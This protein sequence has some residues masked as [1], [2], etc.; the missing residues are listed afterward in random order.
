[1]TWQEL[2]DAADEYAVTE[3]E[4]RAALDAHRDE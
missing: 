4:V 1:M 2:F 3:P